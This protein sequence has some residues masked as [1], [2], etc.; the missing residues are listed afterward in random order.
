M[1]AGAELIALERRRQ[2]ETEGWS[3]HHDDEHEMGELVDAAVVYATAADILANAPEDFRSSPSLLKHEFELDQLGKERPWPWEFEWLKIDPDPVRNLIK[4][5]ALLAAEIDRLLRVRKLGATTFIFFRKEGFCPVSM[6]PEEVGFSAI[7]NPG[8]VEVQDLA[9][10]V[11][12]RAE[13]KEG[14]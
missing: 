10:N 3:D 4:A 8:T 9:G 14:A 11:V 1:K 2:M 5:G 12:W 7:A 6:S 13:R